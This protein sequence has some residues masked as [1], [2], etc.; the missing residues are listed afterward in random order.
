MSFA[1]KC[2][3]WLNMFDGIAMIANCNALP[4]AAKF[5]SA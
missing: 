4:L 5:G 3:A 2:D 1:F